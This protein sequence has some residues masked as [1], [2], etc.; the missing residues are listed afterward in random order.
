MIY[1]RVFE[2]W[3]LFFLPLFKFQR[4]NL[5]HCEC[6]WALIKHAPCKKTPVTAQENLLDVYLLQSNLLISL[7]HYLC[8]LVSLR[9][10]HCGK[11]VLLT[12]A[13]ALEKREKEK[14]QIDGRDNLH[15]SLSLSGDLFKFT[16]DVIHR[17]LGGLFISGTLSV[18]VTD[19]Q[20]WIL[21]EVTAELIEVS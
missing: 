19:F 4:T 10:L 16:R 17:E 6:R 11:W 7:F 3:A 14:G 5:L 8:I 9:L 15:Y 13:S 20:G 18:G 12:P 1:S 2:P 21:V